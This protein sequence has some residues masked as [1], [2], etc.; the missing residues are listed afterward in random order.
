MKYFNLNGLSR[1]VSKICLGSMTFGEQ[2]SVKEAFDFFDYAFEQ[3]VNFVDTA[4]MYSSPARAETQ[5]MAEEITGEWVKQRQ[6]RKD[7]VL[8]TKITGPMDYFSYIRDPLNFSSQQI[9]TALDGS[10]KRLQTDYVDIYQLHWPERTTNYFSKLGFEP[11]PEDPWEDNFAE[12][13]QTMNDLIKEGKIRQFGVSNETAWGLMH[14]IRTAEKSGL[15]KPAT[16]QNPYSLLNR[17]Y[18]VGLAEVSS[19]ENIPLL[20]Y[21]PLGYGLLTGKYHN[22]SDVSKSRLK[23]YPQLARYNGERSHE[24]AKKY[25]ALANTFRL[26]PAQMALSFIHAQPYVASCII[27]VT[28]MSQLKENIASIDT[29]LPEELFKTL[30]EIHNESPNPAP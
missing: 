1:E 16:I 11:D 19:R 2:N 8:A 28:K 12:I 30:N 20:A 23:L 26:K 22:N 15:S 24:A 4:E 3:G 17:T 6:N 21:S 29:V 5:G 9:R 14:Y 25:I 7:V 10:L 13:I 27:G 18:E